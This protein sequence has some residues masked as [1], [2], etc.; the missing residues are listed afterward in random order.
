MSGQTSLAKVKANRRNAARS[1]GPKTPQ[2]KG[3]VK[4]NA[5]KHGL[6]AKEVVIRTG[7]GKESRSDFQGLLESLIQDLQPK[8]V[9]EEMLVEKIAVC[10]WRLRRVVRSE[11][12]EIRAVL[13]T[14]T[15]DEAIRRVEAVNKI[16]EWPSA[17]GK[18]HEKQLVM[19]TAG[20]KQLLGVVEGIR[21]DIKEHGEF[22]QNTE[23]QMLDIF[24]RED[25]SPGQ[26]LLFY[27]W[28]ASENGQQSED[29]G[30]KPPTPDECRKIIL[31]IL[32]EKESGYKDALEVMRERED[33][34]TQASLAKSCLPDSNSSERI[35]RYETAIE[36][37]LYRAM[38]QLERLQRQRRGE[39]TPPPINIDLSDQS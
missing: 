23:K 7:D 16:M 14:Y 35:L 22:S 33:F 32:A 3:A 17:T 39:Y 6:L 36:R 11:V 15:F 21:C 1:T 28:L 13:D 20:V 27:N 34:Q 25:N 31:D 9:L 30:E 38:N 26:E 8:G 37:Q 12:G 4:W 29:S 5:L 2:G 10:Y 19:S 24:G 18:G